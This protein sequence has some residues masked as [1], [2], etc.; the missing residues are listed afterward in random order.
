M[1]S[2]PACK[3]DLIDE[4]NTGRAATAARQALKDSLGMTDADID[5]VMGRIVDL[6]KGSAKAGSTRAFGDVN[7]CKS[8]KTNRMIGILQIVVGVM[9]LAS[10][11]MLLKSRGESRL[12]GSAVWWLG[13]L[14]LGLTAVQLRH[15]ISLLI[16]IGW[17]AF[18]SNT[19][20]S[21]VLTTMSVAV[22]LLFMNFRN[23]SPAIVMTLLLSMA[24]INAANLVFMINSVRKP[25]AMHVVAVAS[26]LDRVL[27]AKRI[28]AVRKYYT[29][30]RKSS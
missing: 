13:L 23:S 4:A 1:S 5:L 29:T 11:A 3:L 30:E 28:A 8:V 27:T 15:V 25:E 22:T 6:T 10:M 17:H 26:A 21:M 9:S 2:T 19:R 18:G 12:F 24:G 20:A 16:K 14:G 7:K